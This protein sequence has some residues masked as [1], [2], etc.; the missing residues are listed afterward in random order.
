MRHNILV[1]GGY[2]LVGGNVARHLRK[3]GFRGRLILAGRHPERG[4][5]LAAQLD[6]ETRHLDTGDAASVAAALQD[7]DIV[8]AALKDP[9]GELLEG[10]LARPAAFVGITQSAD[11]VSPLLFRLRNQ[12]P[13]RPVVTLGHWQAGMATHLVHHRLGQFGRVTDI[14]VAALYDRKDPVGPMT[15]EDTGEFMSRALVRQDGRWRYV[16]ARTSGR[17][18]ERGAAAPFPA[19]PMGVLDVVSLAGLTQAPNV[20]FDLGVAD[21]LGTLAGAGASHEIH[22]EIEGQGPDGVPLK[23]RATLSDPRGQAHLTGVGLVLA[24]QALMEIAEPQQVPAGWH[25]PE[26]LVRPARAMALAREFGATLTESAER[27]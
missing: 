22:C 20:R 17:T 16:D 26:T 21:S 10:A 7:V 24:A 2:G 23:V 25:L 12:A 13:R 3:A 8:L 19:I 15:T 14:R 11:T 18:V 5:G 27:G 4:A 9:R 6:A 1:A